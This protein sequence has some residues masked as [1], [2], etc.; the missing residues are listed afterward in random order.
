MFKLIPQGH[1]HPTLSQITKFW[2]IENNT[3]MQYKIS[4]TALLDI[5]NISNELLQL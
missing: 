4:V 3:S 2:Q 5:D 1:F